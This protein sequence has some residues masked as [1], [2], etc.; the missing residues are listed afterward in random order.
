MVF[1][2]IVACALF[3]RGGGRAAQAHAVVLGVLVFLFL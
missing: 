2:C 1:G 3:L